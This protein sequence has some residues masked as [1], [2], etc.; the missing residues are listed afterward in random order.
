MIRRE[1]RFYVCL[2]IGTFLLEQGLQYPPPGVIAESV[3]LAAGLLL[4]IGALSVG[5][6]VAGVV[7]E[8]KGCIIELQK[9]HTVKRN[10]VNSGNKTDE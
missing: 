8:I 9:L 4:C 5:V 6:D 10:E 1:V 2:V 3:I 7:A